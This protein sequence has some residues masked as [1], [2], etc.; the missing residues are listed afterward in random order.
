MVFVLILA[1]LSTL[2]YINLL[3]S[4]VINMRIN[5]STAPSNNAENAV[6]IAKIKYI[7]IFIMSVCWGIVI[8]GYIK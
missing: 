2:V 7:L 3:I 1:L 4:D 5:P 6:L 8:N